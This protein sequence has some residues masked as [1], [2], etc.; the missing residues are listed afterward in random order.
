M[1]LKDLSKRNK[2]VIITGI[3]ILFVAL[4]SMIGKGIENTTK[5]LLPGLTTEQQIET[6][7]NVVDAN[8]LEAEA[9]LVEQQAIIDEQNAKLAEQQKIIDEQKVSVQNVNNVANNESECR[10]LYADN[11]EC[12][13]S[14]KIYR[15]KVNFDNFMEGEKDRASKS[16]IERYKQKYTICQS[17]IAKCD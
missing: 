3:V 8:K 10:K 16:D 7:A 13:V 12:T 14:N 5:S 4:S 1:K 9:K 17:I 6:V 15:S 2:I 11:P